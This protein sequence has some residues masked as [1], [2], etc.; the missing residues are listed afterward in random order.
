MDIAFIRSEALPSYNVCSRKA[1]WSQVF[2]YRFNNAYARITRAHFDGTYL[3]LRQAHPIVL[4]TDDRVATPKL[5][6]RWMMA[7]P[8][9]K[10]RC[11]EAQLS[12]FDVTR[13]QVHARLSPEG[14]RM[15]V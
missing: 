6:L 13:D 1:D 11:G 10:T 3:Q 4:T 8:L 5:L 15:Y 2:I 14:P 9:S 12:E 7:D